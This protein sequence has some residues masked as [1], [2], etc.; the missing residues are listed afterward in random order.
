MDAD[1][2]ASRIVLNRV[3][4]EAARQDFERLLPSFLIVGGEID[5]RQSDGVVLLQVLGDSPPGLRG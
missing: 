2:V 1:R 4:Y 3:G 5:Q